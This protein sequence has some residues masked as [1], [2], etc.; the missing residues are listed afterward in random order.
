[1]I[2]C[3]LPVA[4]ASS[5]VIPVLSL[6]A[7]TIIIFALALSA[8]PVALPG[9]SPP[10][11]SLFL[12]LRPWLRL[13]TLLSLLDLRPLFTLLSL[14]DLRPLLTL[15]S[16]LPDSRSGLLRRRW[17]LKIFTSTLLRLRA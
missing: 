6:S 5:I 17:S 7:A 12:N 1:M 14:L 9:F 10:L 3:G 8:T 11:R 2:I 16:L 15:L 13:L 4:T